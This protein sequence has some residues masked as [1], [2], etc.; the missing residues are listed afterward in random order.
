MGHAVI[1]MASRLVKTATKDVREHFTAY[2]VWA[3][4][5]LSFFNH[6]ALW[7]PS[8]TPSDSLQTQGGPLIKV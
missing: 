4:G 1:A 2:Q 5:R 7:S 8:D 3:Y 6:E